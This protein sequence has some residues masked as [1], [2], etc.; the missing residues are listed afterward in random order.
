[1]SA[2]GILEMITRFLNQKIRIVFAVYCLLML[3]SALIPMDVHSPGYDFFVL[4]RPELQN[5]LHIPM[6]T[7][8]TLLL[9]LLRQDLANK[10][11]LTPFTIVFISLVWGVVLESLQAFVPGRYPGLGDVL[12]NLSGVGVGLVIVSFAH[13]L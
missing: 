6:F 12:L 4:V 3:A 1:M 13:W 10:K 8:F 2:T 11:L 7:G 5:L 9:V